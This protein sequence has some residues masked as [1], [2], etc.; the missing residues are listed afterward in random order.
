MGY[1]D[2]QALPIYQYLHAKG[3]PLCDRRRLLPRRVRR[4]IPEPPVAHRGRSAAVGRRVERWLLNDLHRR[5]MRRHAEHYS[6]YARRSVR[7]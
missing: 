6:L 7:P 1:Y 4:L 3:I 2:T 5:S